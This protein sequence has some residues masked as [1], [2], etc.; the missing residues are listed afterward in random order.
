MSLK[1]AAIFPSSGIGDALLFLIAAQA[2][3][4][5]GYQVTIFHNSILSLASLIPSYQLLPFPSTTLKEILPSF[6]FILC[7]YDDS[8][9]KKELLSL[10]NDHFFLFY[11]TYKETK[12]GPLS[13]YDQVFDPHLSMVKNLTNSL[14]LLFPQKIDPNLV[15]SIPPDK[16]HRRYKNRVA[17]HPLSGQKEK[18]W[19]AKKYLLLAKK[20]QNLGFQP[21]FILSPL[22]R[23]LF[24]LEHGSDI[25]APEL[26]TL[27]DLG[28]FLYESGYFIGN[29]SGPGHL[30]SSLNIPFITLAD[31]KKRM[32]LW[33]PDW[34]EG[35]L[36]TPPSFIPNFKPFRLKKN[37]W[38]SF[39]SIRKVLR[40][41]HSFT[42]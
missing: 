5:N 31:E 26:P 40:T 32:A 27:F 21:F 4:N 36:I 28:L 3:K 10:R 33:R 15:F 13:S 12:H 38:G 14:S 34:N 9:A 8:K 29:D 17:I 11:P 22:E 24:L 23:S 30:A 2:L 41:L 35:R 6:D 25:P 37:Y 42:C 1:K 20:L 18:N 19:S 16:I 7:Q 39:I